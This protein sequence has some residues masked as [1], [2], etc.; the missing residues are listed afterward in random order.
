VDP[1]FKWNEVDDVDVSVV[2]DV[3]LMMLMYPLWWI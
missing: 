2:V 1:I 3:V